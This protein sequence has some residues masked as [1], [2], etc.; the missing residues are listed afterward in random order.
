MSPDGLQMTLKLRP[1]HK[2]DP[3]P[4]T[5]GRAMNAADVKYSWDRTVGLSSLLAEVYHPKNDA[6]MI[7]TVTTPDNNTVVVKLAFPYGAMP[8]VLGYWFFHISPVEQ[9]QYN[10]RA[11]ARG[12]GPFQMI[13]YDPGGVGIIEMKKNPD[14]YVKGR[15]FLDGM[16]K[17]VITE[18]AAALA[19][20][21]AKQVWTYGVPQ[22]AILRTKK[23][24]P[25]LVM[26]YRNSA[27]SPTPTQTPTWIFSQREDSPFKDVRLR[28]AVSM[29]YDRE[30]HIDAALNLVEFRNAG[31]PVQTFWNSHQAVQAINWMDPRSKEFGENGKYFMYNV[32]E[33]KKLIAASGF[34]GTIPFYWR[35][36]TGVSF[37]DGAAVL[38][39]MLEEGGFKLDS[40]PLDPNSLWRDYKNNGFEAYSG[41][42]QTT[43]HGFN[44]DSL[45]INKYTPVGSDKL[46]SKPLP[47][48]TDQVL[49]IQAERD[50]GKRGEM[51]KTFQREIAPDMPDMSMSLQ[52]R[53]FTLHWPWLENYEVFTSP[54]FS[55]ESTTGRPYNEYWYNPAKKT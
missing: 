24:H 17:I 41:M 8:D 23:D 37:A 50:A 44:D 9:E 51:I 36:S 47:K 6:G 33:A 5:N 55:L 12:S 53:Q 21:E 4:P 43:V 34:N 15:P 26:Y 30:A 22:D 20:F 29:L 19:Q 40:K 2:F 25:E 1:N 16:N 32:D 49:K 11:E 10:P 31:L 13:R 38:H 7:E 27:P 28:Q 35:N 46:S 54:G 45:L 48:W 3:R 18:P 52:Q 14:W 39:G 42:F